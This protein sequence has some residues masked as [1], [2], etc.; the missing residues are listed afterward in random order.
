MRWLDQPMYAIDCESTSL[1]PFEARIIQI[2]IGLSPRPGE[3]KPW[4]R[5]INPGVPIPPDSTA[6]HGYTNE[7]VQAEGGDPREILTVAHEHLTAAARHG[8][9]IVG[10]NIGGYDLNLISAEFRRHGIGDL[11]GGLHSMTRR[12]LER[13]RAEGLATSLEDRSLMQRAVDSMVQELES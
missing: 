2:T 13:L 11:P 4:T 5:V 1:D 12:A 8:R 6:V 7:R 10:H 9:P 3:W